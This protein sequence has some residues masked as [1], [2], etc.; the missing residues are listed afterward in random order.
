MVHVVDGSREEGSENLQVRKHGLGAE[1]GG[2]RKAGVR[3]I[4]SQ[5]EGKREMRESRK[6][7][8]RRERNRVKERWEVRDPGSER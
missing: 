8:V 1:Q 5:R 6:M 4:G 7:G 3:K 2:Q